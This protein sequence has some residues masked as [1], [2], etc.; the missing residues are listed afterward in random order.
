MTV[1]GLSIAELA[2]LLGIVS[3]LIAATGRVLTYL[4][5][6]ITAP[7]IEALN[8]LR[9]EISQLE[10]QLIAEFKR[11]DLEADG[12]AQRVRRME[13]AKRSKE[14]SNDSHYRVVN[15]CQS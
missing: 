1:M 5:R 8:K 6:H 7:L 13:K 10:R 2:A 12:L 11:I 15:E 14:E 9:R 3:V 4:R